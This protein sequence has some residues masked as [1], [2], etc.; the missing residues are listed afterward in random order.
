MCGPVTAP[1]PSSAPGT[2]PAPALPASAPCAAVW[3]AVAALYGSLAAPAFPALVCGTTAALEP[4]CAAASCTAES[5]AR[6]AAEASTGAA[7]SS[8]RCAC[9]QGS[10]DQAL[11]R[12]VCL[13]NCLFVGA[14][15][16]QGHTLWRASLQC[17][18]RACK[19]STSRSAASRPARARS[20]P[21]DPKPRSPLKDLP[22]VIAGH[23]VTPYV[24]HR[25]RC[26]A[27]LLRGRSSHARAHPG[28]A[29]DAGP[30]TCNC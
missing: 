28:C 24:S 27:G 7:M 3:L 20:M 10:G 16:S 5:A 12:Q 21:H 6:S 19:L 22:R 23:C 15:V 29:L 18:G 17:A 4:G 1:V 11:V 13:S 30:A 14:R 8:R 2:C 26:A 9:Q 25:R